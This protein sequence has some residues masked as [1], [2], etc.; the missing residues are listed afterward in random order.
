MR[1]VVLALLLTACAHLQ[2][3]ENCAAEEGK[4]AFA[5]IIPLVTHA[6]QQHDFAVTESELANLIATYG[7]DLVACVIHSVDKTAAG[8]GAQGV[9]PQ[10]RANAK[11]WLGANR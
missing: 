11:R 8:V 2:P 4:A 1:F 7:R 10:I 3:I 9:A 6:L 5:D